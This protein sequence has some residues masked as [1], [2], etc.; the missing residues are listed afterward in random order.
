MGGSGEGLEGGGGE[1]VVVKRDGDGGKD[2]YEKDME[3]WEAWS[4]GCRGLYGMT[5]DEM[6]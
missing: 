2:G 3:N 4:W 5:A 1:V 6:R